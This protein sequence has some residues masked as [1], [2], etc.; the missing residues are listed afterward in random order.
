MEHLRLVFG[1]AIL[2]VGAE[3]LVRFASALAKRFGFSPLVIGL[4]IVGFGTSPPELVV[5]ATSSLQGQ[6]EIAAANVVGSNIFNVLFILGLAAIITPL[7]VTKQLIRFDVL[8]MIGCSLAAY[9]FVLDK[10]VSRIE[11][12]VFVMALVAYTWWLLKSCLL[13]TYPSPRD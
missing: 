7:T 5:S 2:I 8:I 10:S 6:S 3:L 12:V 13:Y 11:G 1:L 9:L 4:T